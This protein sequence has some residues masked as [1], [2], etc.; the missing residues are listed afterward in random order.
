MLPDSA[1][2]ESRLDLRYQRADPVLL[3]N[4][5]VPF[6]VAC[7]LAGL[8][9]PEARSNGSR[10][11]CPFGEFSHSDGGREKAL[12]VYRDHGFCFAEWLY[13]TPVRIFAQVGNLTEED[14]ARQL[15]D[16]TGFKP[17]SWKQH[18]HELV[19]REVV[20]DTENLARALRIW[21][22]AGY[23]RWRERQYDTSVSS[24]LAK[25][26]GLLILVRTEADCAYWLDSAKTV[27]A[28]ELGGS[29]AQ[30]VEAGQVVGRPA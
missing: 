18:W 5:L 29:H 28:R 9:V 26:L 17:A 25:C 8:S 3:A 11:W 15:L 27:M 7:R 4:E 2:S 23:P 22:N 24:A 12:R 13:F 10:A 21:L 19:N 16:L 20:P 1:G 30:D 6:P 14:A